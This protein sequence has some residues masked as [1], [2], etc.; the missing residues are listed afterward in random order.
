[1]V[2][3][4]GYLMSMPHLKLAL[5]VSVPPSDL[6]RMRH[7]SPSRSDTWMALHTALEGPCSQKPPA[8][9]AAPRCLQPGNP[10]PDLNYGM[11]CPEMVGRLRPQTNLGGKAWVSQKIKLR[12]ESL[13][14]GSVS[15]ASAFGSGHDLRVLGYSP[16]LGPCSAGILLLTLPRP[17]PPPSLLLVCLL[18]LS[19]K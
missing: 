1:M 6:D 13:L 17:L 5:K 14:D 10:F 16:A 18:S 19:N 9:V 2:E 15:K 3:N 12:K 4:I 7:V 8:L 11:R